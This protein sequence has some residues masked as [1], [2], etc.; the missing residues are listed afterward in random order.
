PRSLIQNSPARSS[1]RAW[2]P[3][4]AGSP[5]MMS[6]DGARPTEAD[7]DGTP[8]TRP[9]KGPVSNVS[10]AG[11]SAASWSAVT[12]LRASVSADAAACGGCQAGMIDVAASASADAGSGP[13]PGGG[14]PC[15]QATTVGEIDP[16]G[17]TVGATGCG[18][19]AAV[20]GCGADGCESQVGSACGSGAGSAQVGW[21]AASA[22]GWSHVGAGAGG[23]AAWPHSGIGGSAGAGAASAAGCTG[24]GAGCAGAGMGMVCVASSGGTA[25]ASR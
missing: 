2:R 25:P 20:A 8:T 3:E 15:G 13:L 21:A 5:M 17:G 14:V 22:A 19:G 16:A 18:T 24:S 12:E 7:E 6:F 10:F 11:A 1:I 23:G 9:A 4:V